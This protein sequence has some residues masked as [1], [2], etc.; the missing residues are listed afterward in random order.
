MVMCL[1]LAA[2]ADHCGSPE[3]AKAA[4]AAYGQAKKS[5]DI[6]DTAVAAGSFTILAKAIEAAGLVDALKAEGPFTVFAPTDEAFGK[7]P[8]GVLDELL[9]PEN[10]EKLTKI[11][12]YHVVSGRVMAADVVE[13]E[14][15]EALSGDKL[16]IKVA[17]SGVQVANAQVVKTDIL[18]SNG[19]IHVVDTVMLPN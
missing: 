19:V 5:A 14:S 17:K 7:L 13:L 16:S 1:P 15:A 11:L 3:A 9:Q 6:I 12:T 2:A 8:E 4:E 10:K 18:A